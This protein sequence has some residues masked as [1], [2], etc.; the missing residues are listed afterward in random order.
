MPVT[1]N[2][3]APQTPQRGNFNIT[4]TFAVA[5]EAFTAADITIAA[6]SGNGITGVTFSVTGSGTTYNVPFQLPEDVVGSLRISIT[7]QVTVSG[8]SESV[9]ATPRTVAYDNVTTVTVTFGTAAYRD[10]G[11]MAIP[12]T[13]AKA[14]LAP[15]KSIFEITR[16][17]GDSLEGVAYRLVGE[18]TAYALII[19]VPPDRSG[20]LQIACSGYVLQADTLLWDDIT[21]TVK[22]VNYDTRVPFIENYDIP[23]NYGVGEKFDVV[24]Q[25]NVPVTFVD[26]KERFGSDDATFLDHFIFEGA[27]LGTPNLYRKKTNTYP[28]GQIGTVSDTDKKPPVADW[29]APSTVI[30]S[31]IY[32]LR[33]EEVHASAS[34]IFNIT[35]KEDSVRGPT[36]DPQFPAQE[37]NY[38]TDGEG[39]YLGD[40]KGNYLGTGN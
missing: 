3:T 5:V 12:V 38:L 23:E 39:N 30:P 14:V 29:G 31:E 40:G 11:V 7:G 22:T 36:G 34:G 26:P 6:V 35:L 15:A 20:A 24:L 32:L 28:M 8:V 37:Q 25:F 10:R 16:V 1:A 13:F 33:Y 2:I 17:S 21:C 27:D 18:G 19:G 9:T 4:V